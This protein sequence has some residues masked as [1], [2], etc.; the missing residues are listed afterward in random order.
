MSAQDT[1]PGQDSSRAALMRVTISNVSSV[2]EWLSSSSRSDLFKAFLAIST[3]ASHPS[4][5]QSWKKRRSIP[6]AVLPCGP[7][8]VVTVS[9]TILLKSG[10]VSW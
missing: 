1:T 4:K 9:R 6:A 10:H 7:C 5:K 2:R 3:D 8:V